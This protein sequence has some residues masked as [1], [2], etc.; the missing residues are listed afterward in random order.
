MN[1]PKRH[2]S[3]PEMLQK[4]FA[5]ERGMLWF[6]DKSRPE[7]GVRETSASSL[8]VR[9]RQY[10]LTK[11]DGTRDWSLETRYSELE[12]GMNI[13]IGKIVPNVGASVYPNLSPDER[14]LLNR[15]VYEQWRRVPE[16]YD[17]MI[18]DD[19]FQE[20][21]QETVAEFERL[22]RP[23]TSAE[24]AKF[25][26]PAY[27]RSERKRARVSSLSKPSSSA[28]E[29]ISDKGL[30]FTRTAADRSFLI[31]SVPVIKLHPPELSDLR[32]PEVEVWLAIHPNVAI[33]LARHK[34][35]PGAVL[36]VS[37]ETVRT[38]NRAIANQSETFAGRD[39]ALVTS[40]AKRF[41]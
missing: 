33:V 6:F 11:D 23:L 30:Y 37:P 24:R 39:K 18:S 7:L 36:P 8:F 16:I 1:E 29:I 21:H 15:Y 32:L 31:G 13:L 25:A 26:Q 12:G 41:L 27:L 35:E 34:I 2:H 10:T 28:L 19:Q 38:I 40:I 20:M 22:Y 14:T 3:V 5:D 9:N 4:R 17:R